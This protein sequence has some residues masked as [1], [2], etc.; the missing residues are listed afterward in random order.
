M[1]STGKIAEGLRFKS[2]TA[3][4]HF[5]WFTKTMTSIKAKMP[6]AFEGALRNGRQMRAVISELIKTAVEN[7]KEKEAK[8]AMEV[9]SVIRYGFTTSKIMDTLKETDFTLFSDSK[10]SWN[11][12]EATQF[13][14]K[15]LDKS[16]KFAFMGIGYGIT[17]AGNAI[18]QSGIKYNS[19]PV[20]TICL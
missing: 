17:I 4:E 10:L 18:W 2:P 16:V 13:I 14:T 5:D 3:A 7:G 11:K 6:K 20:K 9:L 12:N 1:E 19:T 15:A 8:T